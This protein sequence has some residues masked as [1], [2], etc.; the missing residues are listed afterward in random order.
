MLKPLIDL[1]LCLCAL[2]DAQPVPARTFGILRCQNLNTV[3]LLDLVINI[4]QLAVD[5]C[6]YHLVTHCTVDCIG[7]IHRSR[8]VRQVLHIS[9]RSETV[10][11]FCKQIQ[12][13]F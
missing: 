9:V 6:T 4:D 1:I 2:Y 5:T 3:S 10:H 12:I 8:T 11:I 7:K 13:A